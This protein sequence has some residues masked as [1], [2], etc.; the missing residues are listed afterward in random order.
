MSGW[1][2]VVS[3]ALGAAVGAA[4]IVHGD[5]WMQRGVVRRHRGADDLKNR[6]YEFLDLAARYWASA[7]HGEP[8]ET[9]EARI[10]AS[11]TVIAAACDDMAS[12]SKAL[13]DWRRD[14]EQA[15]LSLYEVVTGGRFQQREDWSPDPGRVARAAKHVAAIASGLDR[16]C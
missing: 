8:R 10:V 11:W 2:A 16:A 1:I 5:H 12:R 3:A 7:E 14:T 6:L 4:V 9:V 13:R 15:R